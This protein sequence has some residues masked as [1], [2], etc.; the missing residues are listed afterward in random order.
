[1]TDTW[2]DD[3]SWKDILETYFMHCI[4]LLKCHGF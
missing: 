1:M 4:T 2:H 3:G